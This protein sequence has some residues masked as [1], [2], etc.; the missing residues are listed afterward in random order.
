MARDNFSAAT[1]LKLQKRVN[2]RCSNPNCRVP[3][4]A[5]QAGSDKAMTIGIAAHIC[6]AA[7][8]GP[9]YD[10]L[11]SAT[12]RKAFDNGIW[13]CSNCAT[14]IDRDTDRFSVDLLRQWKRE[15]ENSATLE[16]GT[17]LPHSD[18][19]KDTL[20]SALTG[21]QKRFIPDAISNIHKA[22]SY[23]LE[24]LDPRFKIISSYINETSHFSIH[25]KEDVSVKMVVKGDSVREFDDKFS[26]LR[27]SGKD[28]E[29]ST[30]D[31]SFE[32][33]KLFEEI[34][35]NVAS[36]VLKVSIPKR[37]AT[38]KLWVK[39]VNGTEIEYFEDVVGDLTVGSKEASF[40]GV[41]CK[42][43]FELSLKD[44]VLGVKASSNVTMTLNLNKWAGVDVRYL[45]Y[46]SKMFSFFEKLAAGWALHTALQVDGDNILTSHTVELGD[47]EF[48]YQQNSFFQYTKAAQTIASY[49]NTPIVFN[50]EVSY[51]IDEYLE[52]L[53]VARIING[54][55]IY[56]AKDI[57]SDI[58]CDLILDDQLENLRL[59]E[60]CSVPTVFNI[61]GNQ[62]AEVTV[63]GNKIQIPPQTMIFN[64]V[65]PK[66]IS[67]KR[68]LKPGD[69]IKLQMVPTENFQMVKSFCSETISH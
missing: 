52:V 63:F 37:L 29:I 54:T 49:L 5:S 40:Y 27:E 28:L 38:F 69:T 1:S 48:I 66:I 13:L 18:D 34:M 55:A 10:S 21:S 9:R 41:A 68:K 23:S 65:L 39:S 4:N 20:I 53:E 6:A 42:N 35:S 15:A 67:R 25:A 3:T 47:M 7:A 33:S 60:S 17:K 19:A 58:T 2:S 45:A 16:L 44:L 59:I 12:Q 14:K 56:H 57:N 31:I 51:S 46:F 30:K 61:V 32:G 22:S 50:P 62:D 26:Y 43:V 24:A 36:G 64:S 8:G 11:M